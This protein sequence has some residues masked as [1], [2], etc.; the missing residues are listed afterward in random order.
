MFEVLYLR[1]SSSN[2]SL[3]SV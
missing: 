2:A 3:T 1:Y